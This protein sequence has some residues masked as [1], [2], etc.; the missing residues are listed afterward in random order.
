MDY[1]GVGRIDLRSLLLLSKYTESLPI[2]P[3]YFE[4][5]DVVTVD[6]FYWLYWLLN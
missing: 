6:H 5:G 2:V 1:G 4:F 3:K